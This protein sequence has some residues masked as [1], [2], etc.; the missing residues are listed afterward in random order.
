LFLEFDATASYSRVRGL[1]GGGTG[2]YDVS[3]GLGWLF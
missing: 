2:I 3:V 1:S